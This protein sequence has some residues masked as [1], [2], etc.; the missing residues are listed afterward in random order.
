MT[1]K[2]LILFAPLAIV[3]L[4]FGMFLYRLA[5]PGDT[6]VASQWVGQPVPRFTLPPATPGIPGLTSADLATGEPRLL[7]IWASWCVPCKAEAP[8]LDQLAREGVII[9]GIAIRD[10]P[11]DVAAFLKETGNPFKRIGSDQTSSV[12]IALGSSGVPETFIIDGKGVI[13]HQIQGIIT[14]AMLPDIRRRLAELK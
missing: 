6:L 8:M 2:Q 12:Q 11:E 9:D 3:A 13:R 10:K 7:N 14:P 4:L 5:A 1:R